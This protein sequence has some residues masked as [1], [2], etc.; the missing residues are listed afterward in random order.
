LR[1]GWRAA[2]CPLSRIAPVA[3]AAIGEGCREAVE[4]EGHGIADIDPTRAAIVRL[5]AEAAAELA[6]IPDL[7][8]LAAGDRVFLAAHPLAADGM[9]GRIVRQMRRLVE[10]YRRE[11][12]IDGLIMHL[13]I[14]DAFARC[15]ANHPAAGDESLSALQGG[16]GGARAEGVGG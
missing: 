10:R 1:S 12:N 9:R 7:P 4:S 3:C 13:E 2:R 15:L 8:E 6:M 14:A 5:G 11:C 16:E